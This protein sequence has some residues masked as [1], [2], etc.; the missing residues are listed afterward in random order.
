MALKDVR[1]AWALSSHST[2]KII[3]ERGTVPEHFAEIRTVFIPKTSDIDD[4]GRII[5]SLEA[6]RPLHTSLA[7]MHLCWTNDGQHL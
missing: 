7:N 3:L 2:H 1:E 5:R 4:N 6:L